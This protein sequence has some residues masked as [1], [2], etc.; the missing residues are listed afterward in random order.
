MAE[1]RRLRWL[2]PRV[3]LPALLAIVV[4]T[5]ILSPIGDDATGRY[6]STRSRA[7]NGSYGL[8]AILDRLGWRTSERL[9]PF[10]GTLDTTATYVMVSTPVAPSAHEI[11]TLLE[12]VRRG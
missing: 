2:R 7:I 12:A 4:L 9:T 5:A 11:H 3:V 10:L 6:L 1:Q 8:R